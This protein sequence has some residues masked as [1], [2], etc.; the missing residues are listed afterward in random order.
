MASRSLIPS[1]LALAILLPS[2]S[3][4]D[5]LPDGRC[6]WFKGNMH[7]HTTA[8]DGSLSPEGVVHLYRKHG[9][10][11]IA[12]TDHNRLNYSSAIQEYGRKLGILV[13]PGAEMSIKKGLQD[14]HYNAIGIESEPQAASDGSLDKRLSTAIAEAEHQGALVTLNHPMYSRLI[15]S[16]VENTEGL[17]FLEIHNQQ[18]HFD[19]YDEWFWDSLLADGKRVFGIAGD[20]LHYNVPSFTGSFIMVCADELTSASIIEAMR[21]GKFYASTGIKLRSVE[22]SPSEIQVR[23]EAETFDQYLIRFVT[24][25]GRILKAVIGRNA[26]YQ[27]KQNASN[28]PYI[29]VKISSLRGKQAWLQPVFISASNSLSSNL[30]HRSGSPTTR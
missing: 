21:E 7:I 28:L 26:N 15:P 5:M 22:S 27:I 19:E 18:M 11:F 2:F 1:V 14:L 23:V 17:R 8:S 6:R 13:I 3:F 29:R 9:F 16:M 4:A 10:D 30:R 12:I 24:H 20:D 25:Q